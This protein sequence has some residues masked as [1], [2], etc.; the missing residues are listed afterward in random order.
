MK[1]K[2]V[3]NSYT[4]LVFSFKKIVVGTRTKKAVVKYIH[5]FIH[6]LIFT[7]KRVLRG[8]GVKTKTNEL[9]KY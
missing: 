7:I 9:Y 1:N 8:Q 6:M 4:K 2:N 5:S 3:C